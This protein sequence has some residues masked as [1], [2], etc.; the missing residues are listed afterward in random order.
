MKKSEEAP[1]VDGLNLFKGHVE[2]LP[3]GVKIPHMGWN[4]IRLNDTSKNNISILLK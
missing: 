3:E 4:R 1:G 2:K